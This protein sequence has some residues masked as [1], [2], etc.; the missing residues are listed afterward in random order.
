MPR[1]FDTTRNLSECADQVKAAGFDFVSRY[2]SKSHWKAVDKLE[3]TALTEAG[4]AVVLVYEDSPTCLNYF[5]FGRGQA[6]GLRA[7]QQAILIGAPAETTIYFAVDFD[8]SAEEIGGPISQYFNGVYGSQ[9]S[10]TAT[11][12]VAYSVGVYGSGDVCKTI[13][14]AALAKHGWLAQ[15][16]AWR[17]HDTYTGWSIR[18][19]APAA[20]INM[21]VDLDDAL[22]DFGAMPPRPLARHSI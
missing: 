5:S 21:S 16:T 2:L 18:Q 19:G 9:K 12:G 14:A 22:G 3:L 4:L 8:A 6:D 13:T 10:I 20:V 17:G 15:S 11:H 1:G 7:A